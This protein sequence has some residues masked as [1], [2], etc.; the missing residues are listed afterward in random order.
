MIL[1]SHFRPC[2][3]CISQS[4]HL[5]I[6]F[7]SLRRN[8]TCHES[9]IENFP[10]PG[11]LRT[12]DQ[13]GISTCLRTSVPCT[14]CEEAPRFV[15]D[16]S[17]MPRTIEKAL[18][19]PDYVKLFQAL[20]VELDAVNG[21]KVW[22]VSSLPDGAFAVGCRMLIDKKQKIDCYNCRLLAQVFS[23]VHG[24]DYGDSYAP[25]AGM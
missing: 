7:S 24:E 6:A 11:L 21:I 23:L 22:Q 10:R 13:Q 12:V 15:G 1:L 9:G 2:I 4:F 5:L 16:M 8:E 25:V 20:E 19:R 17:V 3:V 14:P 18:A